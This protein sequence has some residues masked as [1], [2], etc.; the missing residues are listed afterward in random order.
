MALSFNGEDV[1]L[2]RRIRDY[3]LSEGSIIDMDVTLAG[4]KPVIYLEAPEGTE[5]TATVKLSLIPSWEFSAIYPVVPIRRHKGQTL[6]WSI[7]TKHDGTLHEHHADVDVAY[8]FWE[9]AY[10]N[11][12]NRRWLPLTLLCALQDYKNGTLVASSI[13]ETERRPSSLLRPSIR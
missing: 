10:V 13:S 1:D 12:L 3:N 4:F 6:E 8:L 2:E 11:S 5:I 9:A 7:T